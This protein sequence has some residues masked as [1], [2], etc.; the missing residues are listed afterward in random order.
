MPRSAR[1]GVTG[2]MCLKIPLFLAGC[3]G[4]AEGGGAPLIPDAGR[5]LPL[6]PWKGGGHPLRRGEE[7]PAPFSL[8]GTLRGAGDEGEL[9]AGGERSY[10]GRTKTPSFVW[11]G[12]VRVNVVPTPNWLLTLISPRWVSTMRLAIARPS[13]VPWA[14]PSVAGT[15]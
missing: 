14:A 3:A 12:R 11:K 10:E 13:P 5:R 9:P 6:S 4:Q 15:R 1:H 8:P 7:S 2:G